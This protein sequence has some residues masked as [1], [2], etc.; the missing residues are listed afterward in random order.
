MPNEGVSL[1][2]QLKK[3]NKKK[4]DIRNSHGTKESYIWISGLNGSHHVFEKLGAL[5]YEATV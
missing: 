3:Q 5:F 2:L 1:K 4:P